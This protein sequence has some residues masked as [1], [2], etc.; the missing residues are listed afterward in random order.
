MLFNNVP[1]TV[2]VIVSSE[3]ELIKINRIDKELIKI[4]RIDKDKYTVK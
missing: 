3:T 1:F 2:H 4:N